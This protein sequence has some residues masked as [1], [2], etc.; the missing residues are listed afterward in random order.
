MSELLSPAEVQGGGEVAVPARRRAST[1]CCSIRRRV[2]E[3][4]VVA[5]LARRPRA[6]RGRA[7][8]GQDRAGQGARAAARRC[9]SAASSSRPTCCRP[10]SP[11]PTCCEAERRPRVRLPPGPIFAN[12]V[13]ADEINRATPEDAVRAARGDAGAHGHRRG[14]TR[15][16]CRA[17][18]SCSPRRTPSSWR[19][20]IR[21]PRR[22][23]TASS[24]ASRC[25]A[26]REDARAHCSP[27]RRGRPPALTPVLDAN[28]PRALFAP[29]IAV[30]LPRPWPNYIAG[31]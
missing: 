2:V 3:Q 10:T 18:S 13:L 16:R 22:S 26:F 24:S 25:P 23:S 4:V 28:E 21:C 1:R 6:A 14:Q 27:A 20:P 30:H 31:W 9:R 8:P 29:R 7:R 12:M 11:A 5:V 19:A 15:T 17:R